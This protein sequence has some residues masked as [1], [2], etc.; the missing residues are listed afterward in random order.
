MIQICFTKKLSIQQLKAIKNTLNNYFRANNIGKIFRDDEKS[1]ILYCESEL[2]EKELAQILT[3]VNRENQRFE[4][5]TIAQ[6]A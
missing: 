5:R 6:A 1:K 2:T 4:I 3:I